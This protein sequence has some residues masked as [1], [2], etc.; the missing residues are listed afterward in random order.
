MEIYEIN[1]F[2]RFLKNKMSL[3]ICFVNDLLMINKSF[4]IILSIILLNNDVC[5][6][7]NTGSSH[8]LYPAT[9]HK[10]C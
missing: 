3:Y 6:K 2:V 9:A 5:L 8:K 10:I 1:M 4:S 7:C